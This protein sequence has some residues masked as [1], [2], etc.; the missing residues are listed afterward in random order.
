MLVLVATMTAKAGKEAELERELGTLVVATR[1]E[2]R[3]LAYA[4]HR[5][6]K[7]P[8]RLLMYER[9]EDRDAL[10]AH[11]ESEPFKRFSGLLSGLA[12]GAIEAAT[13]E[14]VVER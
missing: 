2:P 6:R 1:D 4:L 11:M 7:E 5:H 14:L 9:Y 10:R 8:R 3:T 13:Y 12:E